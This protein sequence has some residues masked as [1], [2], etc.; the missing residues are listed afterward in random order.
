VF[1]RFLTKCPPHPHAAGFR[2]G[3]ANLAGFG[4]QDKI[5]DAVIYRP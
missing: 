4:F 5:F 3:A 2:V 1:H